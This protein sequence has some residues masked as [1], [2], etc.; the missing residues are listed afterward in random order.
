[1]TAGK[2]GLPV[3]IKDIN[4]TG[5]GNALKYSFSLL[6][7]KFKRRFIS[8]T[9]LQKQMSLLTGTTD[10][11]GFHDVDLVV[12]A[13]F[14]DLDLKQ[15]MVADIEANC[16]ENTVFASNTSSLPI[17]QIAAKAQRPENVIGLALLLTGG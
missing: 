16:S 8:K 6:N 7:K 12:E 10:Y 4:Q 2:A 9:E 17:A 1:M 11:S 3:R 15:R 13:V 14:E 5:I